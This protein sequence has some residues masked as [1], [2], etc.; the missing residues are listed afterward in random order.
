MG[1]STDPIDAVSK[2]SRITK[3]NIFFVDR[4]QNGLTRDLVGKQNSCKVTI[5]SRQHGLMGNELVREI[6][7]RFGIVNAAA[8]VYGKRS[9]YNVVLGAFK[10]LMTHESLEQIAM[11][12]GKRLMNLD[13]A[14]RLQM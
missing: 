4:Y 3:R 11:K 5:R 7:K 8:K 9:P 10:A 1:K 12:R 2:A 14:K 6:L 13:K